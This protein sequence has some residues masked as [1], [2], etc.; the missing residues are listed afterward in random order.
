[1]VA[2]RAKVS[3]P[4]LADIV[5]VSAGGYPKDVNLY[6][7]QKALDNATY[8]VRP[9]GIIILIAECIEGLGNQTFATWMMEARSPDDLLERIQRKFGTSLAPLVALSRGTTPGEALAKAGTLLERVQGEPLVKLLRMRTEQIPHIV[10]VSRVAAL[11]QSPELLCQHLFQPVGGH[12]PSFCWCV[13]V[14][15]VDRA[16]YRGKYESLVAG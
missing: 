8:A 16:F 14:G 5:L 7:A 9:G 6:Q 1:M 3:V 2:Q 12:L 15:M 13:R 10:Y 4:A 11:K